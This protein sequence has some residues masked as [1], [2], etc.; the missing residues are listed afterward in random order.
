MFVSKSEIAELIA[1]CKAAT[2][3][4]AIQAFLALVNADSGSHIK[5]SN[6]LI[7][8]VQRDLKLST[9]IENLTEIKEEITKEKPI[10]KQAKSKEPYAKLGGGDQRAKLV[11]KIPS[12]KKK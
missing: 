1:Q 10:K 2:L 4:P 7:T 12:R 9:T 3:T 11:N 5:T 6:T 8:N